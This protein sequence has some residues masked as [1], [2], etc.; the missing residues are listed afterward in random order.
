MIAEHY[1]N[2]VLGAA[3]ARLG[4]PV[5]NAALYR[6]VVPEEI[7][8]DALV[9]ECEAVLAEHSAAA[10]TDPIEAAEAHIGKNFST[11]KLLKMKVWWDGIPHEVTP[12]LAAV[13][14]WQDGVTLSAVSGATAFA[15]PP[16]TFVEVAQEA[17]AVAA[18]Q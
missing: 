7:S 17:A 1:I 2:S 10:L 5:V 15:D 11:A 13:F 12:K 3:C 18:G 8:D 16:F 4:Y 9:A 14:A 6:E